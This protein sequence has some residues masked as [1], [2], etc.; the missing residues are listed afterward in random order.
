ML[1]LDVKVCLHAYRPTDT[2]AGEAVAAWLAPRLVGHERVA[3]SE[4][5]LA[6]VVRL[7]THPR[8]FRVPSTPVDA[9]L[10][11]TSIASAPAAQLVRT[12]PDHWPLLTQLVGDLRLRG[13]DIPDA[14]LAAHALELGAT[15]VTLDRGFRRFDGLRVL[16]PLDDG[17]P[18]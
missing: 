1:L 9:L 7:A 10:F 14:A 5:V 11:T 6:S 13:N 2:P 18:D 3:L 4:S 15:L 17:R 16:N 8:V 12:G